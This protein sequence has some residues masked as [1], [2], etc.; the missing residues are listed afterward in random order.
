MGKYSVKVNLVIVLI[1]AFLSLF[2]YFNSNWTKVEIGSNIKHKIQDINID[3]SENTAQIKIYVS[4]EIKNPGVYEV[5]KGIRVVDIIKLAGGTTELANLQ[6]LNLALLVKDEQHILIGV[7]SSRID[8]G[9]KGNANTNKTENS[10]VKVN[11]NNAT[12][13]ELKGLKNIGDTLAKNIVEYRKNN[14][15]FKNIDEIIN[16]PRIGVKTYE[17]LK[18]YITVKE[19]Y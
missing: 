12:I 3:R 13:D 14:G 16:V 17:R 15:S 19:E 5:E 9:D 8:V 1:V 4:G 7:K 11:I 2:L 10:I 18:E 6:D